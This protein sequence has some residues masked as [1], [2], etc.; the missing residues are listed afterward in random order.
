MD[1]R[2]RGRSALVTGSTAGIGLAIAKR[3]AVEGAEVVVTGRQQVKLDA[4][5]AEIREVGPVRGI[6]ADAGT[7]GGAATLAREAPEVDIL[8]NNLGIYESKDFTAITDADWHR[9]FEVNV[10]SGTR[11][12]QAYFPGMRE[13][14]WGRI[15]FVSSESGL[16]PPTD[17][18]HYAVTKSAQL[19]IA[20][21]LAQLTKGSAVTVNTVMPGPTRSE[22]I[23]DFLKS[24]ASSPDPSPEAME[25]E[26]FRVHRPLSLIQ[27]MIEPDE[28]ASMVAYLASPLAS[29]TNGAALRVEGGIVPTVA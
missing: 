14:G 20:R 23:A 4:A 28:I 18:I 25:A 1:L 3:L 19:T 21:G 22:G 7:A 8:V 17:M 13:R 9:L 12:A 6:L 26:F 5:V 27:R 15:V 29:A 16:V 10:V 24:V 2:L 11:L